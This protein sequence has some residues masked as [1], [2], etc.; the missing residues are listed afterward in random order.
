MKCAVCDND[1]THEVVFSYSIPG[2]PN[3][4]VPVCEEHKEGFV[5]VRPLS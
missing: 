4:P 2:T 1:A 5:E 3:E